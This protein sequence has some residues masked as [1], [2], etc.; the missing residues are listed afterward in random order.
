MPH[1]AHGFQ[2]HPGRESAANT[3]EFLEEL[4]EEQPDSR[5]GAPY[6]CS[7]SAAGLL[8]SRRHRLDHFNGLL[9]CRY[10]VW[11]AGSRV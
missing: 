2:Y 5:L 9:N 10:R 4:A 7:T 11:A 8:G 1:V 3:T 6:S